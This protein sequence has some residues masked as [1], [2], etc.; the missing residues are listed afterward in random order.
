M[1]MNYTTTGAVCLFLGKG[2]TNSILLPEFRD[3]LLTAARE[4]DPNVVAAEA[5]EQWYRLKVHGVPTRRYLTLGLGLARQEVET[6]GELKL[7]Q[8]P[9][10]L[11]NPRKLIGNSQKG[12]TMII[13]GGSPEEAR[14][15][16]ISGIHFGGVRY[17]TEHYWETG[18]G[19]VCPRCCGIGH[20]SYKACGNRP[21]L[22]YI[23]AGPHE[24]IEHSCAV[25]TCQVKPGNQCQHMPVKC[26]NCGGKH[27]ATARNCPKQAEA[28]RNS[29]KR[30]EG[31]SKTQADLAA[32]IP[33]GQH[34]AVV[35]QQRGPGRESVEDIPRL[36]LDPSTPAASEAVQERLSTASTEQQEVEM[37]DAP[38]S[39]QT[40]GRRRNR[41]LEDIPR[42][43]LGEKNLRAEPPAELQQDETMRDTLTPRRSSGPG[44]N[45][46]QCG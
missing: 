3:I 12:S 13:T 45:W 24:G 44:I 19:T 32:A 15:L 37:Q 31:N 5:P 16:R 40:G 43:P 35:I 7:K 27:I 34:F 25:T 18:P 33:Q 21:P 42:L 4:A 46:A 30:G 6:G 41:L 2:V 29:K 8:D 36:S 14:N 38:T 23:C 28:W 17:R 20:Y 26:G 11:H 1:N 22:C 9:I 10:W 39:Q